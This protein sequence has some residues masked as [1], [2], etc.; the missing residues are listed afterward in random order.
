MDAH[1]LA[2]LVDIVLHEL[3]HQWF[4]NLVTMRWWDDLWLNEA[5]ASFITFHC[6]SKIDFVKEFIPD[7]KVL[8]YDEYR[9]WAF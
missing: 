8:E 2:W 3:A 6:M 4:G 1:S 7:Y 5:F 9:N